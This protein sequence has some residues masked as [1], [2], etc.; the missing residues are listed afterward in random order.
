[1][2]HTLTAII[3]VKN[4]EERIRRCLTHLSFASQI[5]VVDNGSTDNTK[6]IAIDHN[7]KVIESS[8]KD[9]AS[10]RETG[11]REATGTWVLYIDADEEVGSAL[12]SE[13][14][15]TITSYTNGKPTAYLLK[16]DTYY[17]GH[18]WPYQDRVERLF[19]TRALKGWH[20]RL[21]ETPV[22]AGA[23]ATLT[24]PLVHRTHRTIE[25]MLDKTNDWSVIEAKLR[26]E[27]HHP[28]VVWW[29]FLRVMFT[30]FTRSYLDARGWQ[31]GTVGW[32]ESIYQAF[33]MFITYAKLWEMQQAKKN[34]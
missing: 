16:R 2:K 23:T 14:R 3:I 21:H 10:M 34:S 1:M 24:N 8:E 29:R 32:I 33:S 26:L 31:A 25:E 18:H 9:F 17:L 6:K 5:I 13:I 22:F 11:L 15:K 12:Q 7:A 27:A 28:P 19:V 20:G 30:G 4:E